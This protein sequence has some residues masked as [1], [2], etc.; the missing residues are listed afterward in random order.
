MK[1]SQIIYI[2]RVIFKDINL[3]K[4]KFERKKR[5]NTI[6]ECIEN[7]HKNVKVLLLKI[8]IYYVTYGL[9]LIRKY[10]VFCI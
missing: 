8:E 1:S 7:K 6:I 5:Y 2:L 9:L 10:E 4:H 3:I